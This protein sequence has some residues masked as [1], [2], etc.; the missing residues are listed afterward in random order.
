M[1]T[2]HR[3]ISTKFPRFSLYSRTV[4]G[5]EQIHES[6]LI[7]ENELLEYPPDA[8]VTTMFDLLQRGIWLTNNGKFIGEQTKN[9]TYDKWISYKQAYE[10][11][12]K[13]GSALLELG[14]GAGESSHV[15]IA[16]LNSARYIIA[17]NA[18][19][20]YSI[21]LVP[22]YYN[23]NMEIL[24]TIIDSCNLEL[25]FCDTVERAN[26]FIAEVQRKMLKALKM[27]IIF[28]DSKEKIDRELLR[29]QKIIV[30]H[31]EYVLKLGAEHLKPV[32]PPSPSSI[33]VICH[34]SGTTGAP[35]GVLLSH[36]AILAAM[37][38]MYVQWCVPPHNIVFDRNDIYLSFL[39]LAHIYEQLLQAFMIY[40]G[41]RIGI[42]GGDPKQL[43]RDMKLLRPT[44]L[45]LVPRLLNR[46]HDAIMEQVRKQNIVQRFIFRT[47]L[48][49]KLRQLAKGELNFNTIWDKLV[50][51]KVRAMFGGRLRLITSG[52][53]PIATNVMNF[54]RV[55]FGCLL[56]EGNQHLCNL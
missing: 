41:G 40:I 7:R 1:L 55:V 26:K 14:I 21:V 51:K 53:A 54:S 30:H 50:F 10:A 29:E 3:K 52:G 11:S 18:L 15:G 56:F 47:A 28:E 16:G 42:Y 35:K 38:G 48:K 20:N 8:N 12:H 23:Y 32:K 34:T 37:S 49:S 4:P 6:I 22:L 36:R 33:Y 27:I 31:W 2:N 9:G 25:I 46:Y 43:L 45:A 17:Q 19:I 24:C 44:I 5:S 39:S 13:I